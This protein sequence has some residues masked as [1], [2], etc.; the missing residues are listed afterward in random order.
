MK[1]FLSFLI[2]LLA[3][4]GLLEAQPTF[5]LK[6]SEV[7]NDGNTYVVK[8]EVQMVGTDPTIFKLG[9]S[10][11]Q[12]SFPENALSNP[13]VL[14]TDA[15]NTVYYI[16]PF[17]T[18]PLAGQCS[19][20]I[21]LAVPGV[22]SAIA[23]APAWTEV[24]HLSFTIDNAAL[25]TP[26]AWTYN[27]GTT[28]T[29]L[30]LDDEAQQIFASPPTADN[31]LFVPLPTS[32]VKLTMVNPVNH[33][34]KI[35]NYGD[36]MEDI[37]NWRLCSNFNY[38]S[39]G[40]ASDGALTI[41]NGDFNLSPNE[42]VTI[43][44]T[45]ATGFRIDGDDV[46]LY[47][48][49]G[50]FN[51]P[52]A[53]VDFTQYLTAGNGRE[54][55]AAAKGIWTTGAFIEG[56]APYTY[57]GSGT[58]TGVTF[59]Q[60]N[61]TVDNCTDLLISEYGEPDGGNG[62]YIELYNSSSS[63]IDLSD[64]SIWKISNGG[65]WPEFELDLSGSLPSGAT[66]VIAN[67]AG[68]VPGAN[69]YDSGIINFN[70]DD[71]MGLAKAG[72]LIDAI[73]EEGPDPGSGFDV[74]GITNGTQ[75][76]TLIRKNTVLAPNANWTVSAGT[77]AA[78][79]EWIVVNYDTANVGLHFTS[80]VEATTDADGDGIDDDV[81][82]CP[83]IANP[84]QEDMD[85]DG[86][87]DVC[88]NDIDG[89][90]V[91][92]E[93]DCAPMDAAI[94]PGA[95]CDDGNANTVNDVIQ[96]DCS[97]AGNI[98]VPPCTELF[99]SEY[100][101]PNGGN[102]K[103]IEIYNASSAQVDLS[104]Y[105]LWKIGNGG[106][107]PETYLNLS[108]TLES[109]STYVIANNAGDVP[110]A[111]LY[112]SFIINFNG[113][114]AIGLAKD[115][116]LID[117]VGQDGPDP[118]NGFD[119]AGVFEGT[120]DHTLLRKSSVQAPNVSWIASAGTDSISSEW[121]VIPYSQAN[122]GS[123]TSA[124]NSIDDADNDGIADDVDN[125]PNTANPNQA[126]MDGDD[127]GDVCDDDIDGDGY[128]NV[129]D[130]DSLNA[131]LNAYEDAS[132]SITAITCKGSLVVLY[133]D[134]GGTFAFN[135]APADG[136]TIDPTTG[137]VSNAIS[138]HT[139]T[140]EYTTSG[141]CPSTSTQ[142]FTALEDLE[143]PVFETVFPDLTF[144]CDETLP[145]PTMPIA[146]D[147]CSSE[148]TVTYL[149][150][151]TEGT[152]C[153]TVITRSW[154]ATDASGNSTTANQT[155]TIVDSTPPEFDTFVGEIDLPC[156]DFQ[157]TTLSAT[158]NC[159]SVTVTYQDETM[160]DATCYGQIL[161]TYTATDACGN[162]S[163][164]TQ[165][166][167][168]IDT[169]LPQ[170][171]DFPA[172]L[173]L[174]CGDALPSVPVVSGTDNCDDSPVVV[175]QGE[176]TE[177]TCPMTVTRTWTI[178]DCSGNQTIQEQ[179]ISFVDTSAIILVS[180]PADV[181]LECSEDLPTDLPMATTTDACDSVIFTYTDEEQTTDCQTII[182]RTFVGQDACGNLIQTVQEITL[183]D[184]TAPVFATYV[185]EID[186]PCDA[187]E[188]Y[189][190]SATDACS[191]VTLTFTDDITGGCAGTFI[192]VYTATDACGNASTATVIIHL[193]D[194]VDPVFT[195]FPDDVNLPCGSTIPV[196]VT[197]TGEDNCSSEVYI[198]YLGQ[199]S[200]GLCPM[201]IVRTWTLTDECDNTV[202][203]SQTITLGNT[204][205]PEFSSIPE[206]V[207]INCDEDIPMDNALAIANG[208]CG[209]AVVTFEDVETPQDCGYIITRTFTATDACG[210]SAT[211]EQ[212]ITVVDQT[213]PVVIATPEDVTVQCEGDIPAAEL[214]EAEDNCDNNL[215][216]QLTENVSGACP[217]T[218][219]RSWV[220]TD[221]CGNFTETTQTITVNDTTEPEFV[222]FPSDVNLTCYDEVPAV[223]T[224]DVADNCDDNPTLTMS[225]EITG[226]CPFDMTITRTW[227]LVDAC[228]NEVTQAQTLNFSS[229]D[230]I[231]VY[232]ENLTN[233][234]LTPV[235]TDKEL[236]LSFETNR[237]STFTVTIYNSLGQMITQNNLFAKSGTNTYIYDVSSFESGIYFIRIM[238]SQQVS[239]VSF[240]KE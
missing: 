115:S 160:A 146:S 233:I 188:D 101:E 133:G 138:N 212:T 107:W 230:N 79:S 193:I 182:T 104:A 84:N 163:S 161:R 222:S 201:T 119:V 56:D 214:P 192:R 15:L 145:P 218:I 226:E 49:T 51:S 128:L 121:L 162:S 219:I 6:L 48:A 113:D 77:D 197:P 11:L 166:I 189:Y 184:T 221:D 2:L 31:L 53:M 177:G 63:A 211:A 220:I 98:P 196:V 54:S 224:P 108:G 109:D 147:F 105:S 1:K 151:T 143:P 40:M 111:D 88:D 200:T 34:I 136:A 199:D 238:D 152:T 13:Q 23:E 102:G 12:F 125:C 157:N 76:H 38:T 116:V 28:G 206:N 75:N 91:I 112:E 174:S 16:T 78:T 239:T 36:A 72:V 132:F 195:F 32:N 61:L 103:Y 159:G 156:D 83:T 70:G 198:E 96:N 170:F 209:T 202:T 208:S 68:D 144:E 7:S 17:A 106:T 39:S 164:T 85:Q 86:M 27:G 4:N 89:D 46:G 118:G 148:L 81:D 19:Y 74:A 137:A 213:P 223:E 158:D 210:N 99:I 50:A 187:L 126:D 3:I 236:S 14:S 186:V 66:F 183:V 18:V 9:S 55:V 168:L 90:G 205:P 24:G 67:N 120:K 173:I 203:Q 139:Y 175:Y 150:E 73:G 141:T 231:E 35:K 127:I 64:Y 216:I 44:W 142:S 69:L 95:T 176:T 33:Q 194:T 171:T 8:M 228:G 130:C 129:E 42:E 22:G 57:I 215:N 234:S 191:E 62:K 30:Y 80:C 229:I 124:C 59:W 172:N 232:S 204:T 190:V 155:I 181:T 235:P 179:T 140:I 134:D 153:E 135:P 43:E 94:Y 26:L 165:V 114:D 97:C 25:L 93:V 123:H 82:N 52:D 178:T 5:G 237:N 227:T 29:V 60:G 122:L 47:Y 58:D 207:V 45:P 110:G 87:G 185:P 240:I 65:T 131:S 100:G 149:G 167:H 92:N 217:K 41:I 21:E 10:S 20:N 225:E 154:V 71:A 180:T 169:T 37:S 117:A